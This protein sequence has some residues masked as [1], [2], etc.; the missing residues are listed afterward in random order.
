LPPISEVVAV[1]QITELDAKAVTIGNETTVSV[2]AVVFWQPL[3]AVV[4]ETI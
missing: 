3:A 4:P 2:I 1:L